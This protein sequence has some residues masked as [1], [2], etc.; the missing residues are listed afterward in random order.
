MPLV[1]KLKIKEMNNEIQ[2][3]KQVKI[4]GRLV[5]FTTIDQRQSLNEEVNPNFIGYSSEYYIDGALV[6]L[7]TPAKFY[8]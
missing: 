4:N 7:P 8:R 3:L 5:P 1:S 2:K 6:T